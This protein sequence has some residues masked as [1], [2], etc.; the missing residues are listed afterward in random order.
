[1][2][3][4]TEC[5]FIEWME[6]YLVHKLFTSLWDVIKPCWS[7]RSRQTITRIPERLCL[8]DFTVLSFELTLAISNVNSCDCVRELAWT[9]FVI[10]ARKQRKPIRWSSPFHDV[11]KTPE[12]DKIPD[13]DR[14]SL[15]IFA[16]LDFTLRYDSR[17]H[18][19][20]IKP[21]RTLALDN[22]VCT[23]VTWFENLLVLWSNLG[24]KSK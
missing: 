11:K 20:I 14:L 7:L 8:S 19:I 3:T 21:K 10:C 16:K 9:I 18:H 17:N 22:L 13:R 12:V 4:T 6:K 24:G 1:M 23:W 2:S 5:D 15:L